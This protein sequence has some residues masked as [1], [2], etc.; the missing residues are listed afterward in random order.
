MY[1]F[2]IGNRR[3]W[4][5][6]EKHGKC[7]NKTWYRIHFIRT[8][9]RSCTTPITFFCPLKIGIHRTNSVWFNSS[10][11]LISGCSVAHWLTSTILNNWP[12]DATICA[13]CA[14]D[15]VFK[16]FI[17]G[18]VMVAVWLLCAR[19]NVIVN[20]ALEFCFFIVVDNVFVCWER[21]KQKKK[22]KFRIIFI[23]RMVDITK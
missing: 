7:E 8:L 21:R 11:I 22:K 4:L 13:I 5:E 9:S 6:Y 14:N 10:S 1:H 16:S 3:I 20:R 12:V 17:V 15:D 23:G 19:S 2:P 18:R